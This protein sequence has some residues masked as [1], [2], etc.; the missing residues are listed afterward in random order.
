MY[1]GICD[2]ITLLYGRKLAEHCKP[3]IMEKIKI[4][5]NKTIKLLSLKGHKQ[6]EKA[7]HRMGDNIYSSNI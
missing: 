1:T 6:S 3:A 5:K 2:C 4:I 7:T